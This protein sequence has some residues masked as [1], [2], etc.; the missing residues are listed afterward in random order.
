M[1]FCTS[2]ACP[3]YEDLLPRL[4]ELVGDRA[5]V[6]L[7]W[8][9]TAE[10]AE[11]VAF[12]GSP[13]LRVDGGDGHSH[14][15]PDDWTVLVLGPP[16]AAFGA[17]AAVL[18]LRFKLLPRWLGALAVLVFLSGVVVPWMAGVVLALWI[19]LTSIVLLVEER[20]RPT[21]ANA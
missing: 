7:H 10:E 11:R 2:R 5:D 21:A 14:K 1:S 6:E 18:I 4:R 19:L 9:E 12:L 3:G 16:V 20:K 13:T 8:V 17:S 15:P